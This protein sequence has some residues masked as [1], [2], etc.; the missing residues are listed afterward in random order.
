MAEMQSK[1]QDRGAGPGGPGGGMGMGG[2]GGPGADAGKGRR[3]HCRFLKDGK[4]NV[5]YKDIRMLMKLITPQG[6][7][8][9]RKRSGACAYCQRVIKVAVKRARFMAFL[10]FVGR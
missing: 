1:M 6:K 5:D 9:S 4:C 10:P 7:L 2:P 8:Y 3:R